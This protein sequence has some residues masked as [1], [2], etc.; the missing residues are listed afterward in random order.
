MM[1]IKAYWCLDCCKIVYLTDY[2]EH[3]AD[4]SLKPI[5]IIDG[6]EPYCEKPEGSD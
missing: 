3:N 5:T 4:H 2:G 1:G 6:W